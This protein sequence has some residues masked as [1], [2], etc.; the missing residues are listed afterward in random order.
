M[1]QTLQLMAQ[2]KGIVGKEN[3]NLSEEFHLK[4]GELMCNLE[5]NTFEAAAIARAVL[6][7]SSIPAV[8]KSEEMTTLPLLSTGTFLMPER[9]RYDSLASVL[10][11]HTVVEDEAKKT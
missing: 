7:I 6:K 1:E 3:Q 4:F 2:L 11:R 8:V 10:E 9:E 5:S